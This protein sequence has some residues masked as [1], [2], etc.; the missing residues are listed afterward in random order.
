MSSSRVVQ[1]WIHPL[2]VAAL[3]AAAALSVGAVLAA[4]LGGGFGPTVSLVL[5]LLGLSFTL[6]G[7][8][9]ASSIYERQANQSLASEIRITHSFQWGFSALEAALL[10]KLNDDESEAARDVAPPTPEEDE[11]VEKRAQV[12]DVAGQPGRFI[13]ARDIPLSVIGNLVRGWRNMEELKSNE[14]RW[15]IAN[16][17]GAWRPTGESG[18]GKG[19][20]PWYLTFVNSAG[21][22]RVWRVYRG[23]KG[24]T[25]PTVRDVTSTN[26]SD[27][28]SH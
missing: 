12:I 4:V 1:W 11:E 25:E 10:T 6:A 18:S 7:V 27:G 21:E 22:I 5:S 16:L 20:F 19:N 14:G 8:A 23:G 17:I 15:S 28:W 2:R 24:K 26:V 9:L 3:A 13:E